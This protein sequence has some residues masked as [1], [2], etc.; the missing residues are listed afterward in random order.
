MNGASACIVR[1]ILFI[2]NPAWYHHSFG[3]LK[4]TKKFHGM[5][6]FK[7]TDREVPPCAC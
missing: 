2:N 1:A 5:K 7:N 6:L 3:G 4:T